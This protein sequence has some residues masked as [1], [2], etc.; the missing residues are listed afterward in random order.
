MSDVPPRLQT[1][2]HTNLAAGLRAPETLLLL[3]GFATLILLMVAFTAV[4]MSRMIEVNQRLENIAS[5][6]AIKSEL[7]HTMRF[8][9]RERTLSLHAMIDL[10]DFFQ[11]DERFMD[12][13]HAGALF[14]ESRIAMLELNL[15]KRERDLLD[16][17][18]SATRANVIHQDE[19]ADLAMR[20]EDEAA[21]ALLMNHAIPG[22]NHVFEILNQLTEVQKVS[23]DQAARK[24]RVEF[25][26]A[27]NIMFGLGALALVLG[28]SI[29]YFVVNK[30]ARQAFRKLGAKTPASS[31]VS[32]QKAQ[33]SPPMTLTVWAACSGV[34]GAVV[35][36]VTSPV[37]KSTVL[38]V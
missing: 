38:A 8:A 14:V 17:Q 19:V 28:V 23:S 12:F 22:Q 10:E 18:G 26:E 36:S 11:R 13:N 4:G 37:W 32:T 30:I 1:P 2:E 21:F 31:N 16:A 3:L 27:R 6:R 25:A 29:A 5:E 24:T 20:G 33:S 9:S 34:A 35:I 7:V 15:S